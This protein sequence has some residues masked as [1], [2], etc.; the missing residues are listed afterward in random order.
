VPGNKIRYV[1][2]LRWMDV[3]SKSL[4]I[5]KRT[6]IYPAKC[7]AA[8]WDVD[9]NQMLIVRATGEAQKR[10]C[11]GDQDKNAKPLPVHQPLLG[12]K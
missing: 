9:R 10:R 6:W 5:E 2:G 4:E 3:C 11:S 1:F 7:A 8:F 12:S